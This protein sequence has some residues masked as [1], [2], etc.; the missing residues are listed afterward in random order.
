MYLL[1][2][3]LLPLATFV[4]G[5]LPRCPHSG[6]ANRISNLNLFPSCTCSTLHCIEMASHIKAVKMV[7]LFYYYYY[8]LV[9][10]NQLSYP[11]RYSSFL[12]RPTLFPKRKKMDGIDCILINHHSRTHLQHRLL[13]MPRK[14]PNDD[15]ADAAAEEAWGWKTVE[16]SRAIVDTTKLTQ[17]QHHHHHHQ[18]WMKPPPRSSHQIFSHHRH[19]RLKHIKCAPSESGCHHHHLMRSCDALLGI[20]NGL[21]IMLDSKLTSFLLHFLVV[22]GGELIPVNRGGGVR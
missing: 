19:S 2:V 20:M 4:R 14:A 18:H 3:S 22:F 12:P 16:G 13:S 15:D 1:S 5:Y 7:L 8:E 17:Q 11:A 9:V 6:R 10:L 21:H